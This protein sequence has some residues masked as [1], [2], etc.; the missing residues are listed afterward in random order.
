MR[1]LHAD[2]AIDH[3]NRVRGHG[4]SLGCLKGGP[5]RG[6]GDLPVVVVAT[7]HDEHGNL[8]SRDC[9]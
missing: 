9:G 6:G 8:F 3:R 7:I 2:V 5:Q 1:E 4:E